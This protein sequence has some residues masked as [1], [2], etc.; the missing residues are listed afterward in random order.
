MTHRHNKTADMFDAVTIVVDDKDINNFGIGPANANLNQ[1][2]G[3]H[4][5]ETVEESPGAFSVFFNTGTLLN[6]PVGVS[7]WNLGGL[8]PPSSSKQVFRVE[9]AITP[10]ANQT[11]HYPSPSTQCQFYNSSELYGS[12]SSPPEFDMYF[13]DN[14]GLVVDYVLIQVSNLTDLRGQTILVDDSNP[15]IH[16]HGNWAEK[17][18][19]FLEAP[20]LLAGGASVSETFPKAQPHGNGTHTSMAEGDSF[21]FSFQVNKFSGYVQDG[22]LAAGTS[23]LVSGINP[24]LPGTELAMNFTI[25]TN[26][27]Q[28]NFLFETSPDADNSGT[29]HFVY[30]RNDALEEAITQLQSGNVSAIID[31]LTYKP[32]FATLVDSD[33][34]IFSSPADAAP[35]TTIPA[36]S[37][38]PSATSSEP[39]SAN[40]LARSAVGG[41]A[42]GGVVFLSVLVG[43]I[44]FIQRIRGRRSLQK[45]SN[46][47]LIYPYTLH[48]PV[49]FRPMKEGTGGLN[50]VPALS[51]MPQEAD[52][53]PATKRAAGSRST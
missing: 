3:Y 39:S 44:W 43:V 4:D 46:S 14:E 38:S 28:K 17:R 52:G 16:W 30:F 9:P 19:Y 40:G 13:E 5:W 47:K 41:I 51:T 33:K 18:D 45:C 23:I 32:S 12:W 42:A 1:T 20:D 31:Y 50:T 22:R 48:S 21:T 24:L 36:S 27:T 26:S 10:E 6:G 35:M 53:A 49:N 11:K 34:P 37:G 8:K 15:E 7:I 25:D 29:P 2:L